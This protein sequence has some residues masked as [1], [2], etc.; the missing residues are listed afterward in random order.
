MEKTIK[1]GVL[2][3]GLIIIGLVIILFLIR[4]LSPRE[5]DDVFPGIYCEKEYLEKAYIL[6]VIP[7]YNNVLIS[8]NKTWCQE[9]LNLNKKLGL[10]GV[11]HQPYK[12]FLVENRTIEYLQEGIN[13][14]EECFNQTPT[15]FKA[16]QLALSSENKKMIKEHFPELKIRGYF[17][18]LIHKVYHC[19]DTGRFSN[20][21]IDWF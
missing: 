16:P 11:K 2:F 19:N 20:R 1:K 7:D 18:Q 8:E 12:E 6:W 13:L 3:V 9:I 14:F 21:F 10:H 5:I 17:N 15:K 4:L